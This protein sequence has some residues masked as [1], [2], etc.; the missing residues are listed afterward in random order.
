MLNCLRGWNA[1]I[2]RDEITVHGGIE[3]EV[4]SRIND[5]GKQLGGMKMFS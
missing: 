3:T 2:C 5:V 4:N 1:F